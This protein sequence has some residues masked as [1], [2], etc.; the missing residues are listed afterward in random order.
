MLEGKL[1]EKIHAKNTHASATV[2]CDG[3]RIFAVF[4]AGD[5]VVLVALT[6]DG[7]ELWR[8][9]TGQYKWQYP[10][11]YGAS[12]LIAGEL[13]VVVCDVPETGYLVAYDRATGREAWRTPRPS[14]GSSSGF[15]T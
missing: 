13:V 2:A 4:L 12:P 5:D 1:P 3:E 11:G 8:T 7:R 15:I 9:V 14:K 10:F 6:V